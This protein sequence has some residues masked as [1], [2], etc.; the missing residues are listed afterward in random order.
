MATPL[1][2]A[3]GGPAGLACG[4]RLL[5]AG[6]PVTL[7]ERGRYPLKKVCGEFL[8]PEGWRRVE[9]LEADYYL[10]QRPRRL[11]RARFY[12]DGRR[13]LDLALEPAAYGLSRGA[14]DHAL[15]QRFQALGGDLRQGSELDAA[16]ADIDARGRPSEGGPWFGYKAYLPADCDLLERSES[17]LLMLPLARGYA[18]VARIEDGRLSVCLIARS[19]APL[20]GLLNSHPLL[21]RHSER[22]EFHASVAGFE[23]RAYAGVQ[24]IGDSPRVWPPVVGDG[25]PRALAEWEAAAARTLAGQP[26]SPKASPVFVPA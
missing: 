22:L 15:A 6:R 23:L 13:Y 2:I 14:L 18:G 19:P 4:I 16:E 24:R 17:D 7:H 10:P 21:A 3:G 12:A 9:A 26:T 5:E 20:K 11:T 8:S 25:I 1:V